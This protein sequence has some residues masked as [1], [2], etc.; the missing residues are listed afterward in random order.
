MNK[1]MNKMLAVWWLRFKKEARIL[2]SG[3]S[4]N[5]ET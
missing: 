5:R 2:V 1:L 3:D 4:G